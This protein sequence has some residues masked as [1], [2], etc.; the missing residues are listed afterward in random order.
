MR[1]LVTGS[2]Y[3]PA[4]DV[5]NVLDRYDGSIS[6]IIV[7]DSTGADAAARA[8][9]N[10]H[11][12]GCLVFHADPTHHHTSLNI[13]AIGERPM[14]CL[15][16]PINESE[17]TNMIIRL[18]REKGIPVTIIPEFHNEP[19]DGRGTGNG[20]VNAVPTDGALMKV[21]LKHVIDAYHDGIIGLES[22]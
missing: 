14:L 18:A 12:V 7:G 10:D 9:A 21:S 13:D 16:F 19:S 11:D 20:Y 15:A 17:G 8:W 3:R 2:R 4:I 22:L 6:E 5:R 1:V